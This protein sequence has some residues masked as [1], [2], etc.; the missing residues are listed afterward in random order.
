[1]KS[2]SKGYWQCILMVCLVF[3]ACIPENIE[4]PTRVKSVTTNSPTDVTINS[5]TL[6]AHVDLVDTF[7]I[8]CGFIYDTSSKLSSQNGTLRSTVTN[9]FYSIRISGLKANTTYYYRAY[10][11][12]SKRDKYGDVRSFTTT[13][14]VTVTSGDAIDLG[15]SVKWANCNVGAESPEEY[16]SY[17]AWGETEEKSSYTSDNSV[18]YGLSTSELE[19]RGIIGSDGNLTAEYDAATANW[20]GDWR[21]P[22]L[23]EMKELINNCSWSW[24][25]QNGVNGYKVTG[26]N[27]NSIFL[28]AAG[29]RYRSS[30]LNAGSSGYYWSASPYSSSYGA[31][32]LCFS[33]DYFDWLSYYCYYGHAVRPVSE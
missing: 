11:V 8:F 32:N 23:D 1:M 28:P 24:T 26:S 6:N 17:F 25:T 14:S 12:D 22:T 7:S 9:G 5:A 33:S 4:L 29:Y 16:G 27:G 31:C 20:G 21:M 19:S 10:A 18:T 15:L 2:I 30:L 3:A 13:S